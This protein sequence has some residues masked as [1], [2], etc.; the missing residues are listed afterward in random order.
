MENPMTKRQW[1]WTNEEINILKENYPTKITKDLLKILPSRSYISIIRK[2]QSLNLKYKYSSHRHSCYFNHEFFNEPNLLNCFWAGW[3]L[4]DGTI[5]KNKCVKLSISIDDKIVIESFKKDIEYT[6]N[7]HIEKRNDNIRKDLICIC[8]YSSLWINNLYTHWNCTQNKSLTLE[9]PKDYIK[10]DL[11]LALICGFFE[12]DGCFCY[13]KNQPF[14]QFSG[15]YNFLLWIK[16]ELCK[17]IPN[18]SN[19]KICKDKNIFALK[20]CGNKATEIRNLL[21]QVNCPHVLNRKWN[22]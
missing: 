15:T 10:D 20:F 6:G 2:A 12:G 22:K 4:S 13:V 9:P 7:I 16:N 18:L 3:L 11:A 21:K 1:F 5:K 8:I 14:I 17:K 19:I